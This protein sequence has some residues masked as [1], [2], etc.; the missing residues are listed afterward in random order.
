VEV[1]ALPADRRSEAPSAGR[2]P[3]PA[4]GEARP[5]SKS[6]ATPRLEKA[7]VA[8]YLVLRTVSS[9]SESELE[10][11]AFFAQLCETV[12]K[13]VKARRVAFWRLAP[14][15]T[16]AVEAAPYGFTAD[17]PVLELRIPLSANGENVLEQ[18]VARDN[19][20]MVDGT[21]P[22]LDAL[23]QANGLEGIRNSI[24][25]SW[26]AGDRPIGAL[27]AYDS[28]RGFSSDDAWVMRVAA[29]A[30]GLMWQYREAEQK[31]GTSNDR[32]E[33]EAAARR[34]LL[35]NIGAGGDEAR[36]RF[37]S[38]LHDD[39]LQLLTGAELQLE[40]MRNEV[41]PSKH[42]EQLDQLET[43]LK[44]VEDS[45]RRLL[46]N[47]SPHELD[48]PLGLDEAIR[49]RLEALRAKTGIEVDLDLRLPQLPNGT[50]S[51]IFKNV[52]EALANVEKHAHATSIRLSAN[53]VD[54]GVRVVVV[55]DGKGF[56]VAE[57]ASVPGHLG[58]T[59]M[60][61]RALIAGGRCRIESEPGAG[62]RVEFWIPMSQ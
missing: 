14:N 31:L 9:Y 50:A 23:W 62:A 42:S 27:V 43:T 53:V 46:N 16:L 58:L 29:M 11:P 54:G 32:L 4:R 52:S 1:V 39:S 24:A 40:R 25:V 17:S 35:S 10:L 51:T 61:E 33:M 37:A 2:G 20:D 36:R 21:S 45:L 26:R 57:S 48:L 5:R 34:Q 18:V 28:R 49:G 22:E 12:A 19:L 15:R 3:E 6:R 13:L 55:D 38:T 44:Q 56:I 41:D 47:V 60:R 30:T 8:G 7:Q 59:T